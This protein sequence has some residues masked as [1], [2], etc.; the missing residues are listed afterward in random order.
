[1]AELLG[2]RPHGGGAVARFAQNGHGA[3]SW[4]FGAIFL[5]PGNLRKTREVAL[6][7]RRRLNDGAALA[8]A[9][10]RKA[11][12]RA[13]A[14][15]DDLIAIFQKRALLAARQLERLAAARGQF[16]QTTPALAFR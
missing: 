11:F 10:A 2:C 4:T 3:S 8:E 15:E 14:A 6:L 5:R 1:M 16:E 9:D 7:E 13:V 12:A